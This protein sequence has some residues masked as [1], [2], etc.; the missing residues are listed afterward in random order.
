MTALI[1]RFR[2]SQFLSAA[3]LFYCPILQK[4]NGFLPLVKP[5]RKLP[6][7]FRELD[8]LMSRL[9]SYLHDS[10][11]SALADA[12]ASLPCYSVDVTRMTP[13]E[14]QCL[15]RDY[16]V[17]VSAYLLEGKTKSGKAR[18]S[19]PRNVALPFT[20]LAKHL[21][22]QWIMSY[23]SY[24]LSNHYSLIDAPKDSVDPK[25]AYMNAAA[26]IGSAHGALCTYTP[27][28]GHWNWDNLRLVRAFDGG[29]EET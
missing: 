27:E 9:P 25:F 15:Y 18:D 26:P 13:L 10:K 3:S 19:V 29:A 16:A 6:K 2:S 7:E 12:V 14:M 22:Q 1:S 5:L 8:E 20:T 11:G 21:D 17:L 24:C 23:D 4:R 28:E